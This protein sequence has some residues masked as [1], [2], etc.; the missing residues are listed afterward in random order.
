LVGIATPRAAGN[1]QRPESHG[2][3]ALQIPCPDRRRE[4][5]ATLAG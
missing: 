3:A 2:P 1:P 4:A 5:E